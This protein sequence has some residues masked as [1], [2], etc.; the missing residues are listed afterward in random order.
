MTSGGL[1][2][3]DESIKPSSAHSQLCGSCQCQPSVSLGP[4]TGSS[5][6]APHSPRSGCEQ[7]ALSRARLHSHLAK[8]RLGLAPCG[9]K[10]RPTLG[11]SWASTAARVGFHEGALALSPEGRAH[12]PTR[13]ILLTALAVTNVDF[14]L[15]QE[16]QIFKYS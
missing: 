6:S 3:K 5:G 12:R 8:G 14:F 10:E 13:L 9:C 7:P 2:H 11:G 16:P 4:H 1:R 15:A